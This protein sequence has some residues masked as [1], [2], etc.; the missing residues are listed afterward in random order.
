MIILIHNLVIN[1]SENN[2]TLMLDKH[3]VD[4]N[5]KPVYETLGYYTN[6]ASAVSGARDYCIKKRL[7]DVVC[8]LREAIDEINQ[9]TDEFKNLL[10]EKTGEQK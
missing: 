9:I 3:T 5:G 8:D 1:V 6:L 2:Y 4:K 7:G 10:R